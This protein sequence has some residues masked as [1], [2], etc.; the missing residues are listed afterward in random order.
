[1]TTPPARRRRPRWASPASGRPPPAAGCDAP[2]TAAPE[3]PAR[4]RLPSRR[5]RRHRAD[6]L[7]QHQVTGGTVPPIV[8]TID[9]ACPPEEV[10][11]YVTDPAR[12]GEWQNDVLRV[13]VDGDRFRTVRRIGGVERVMTQQI[14]AVDPPRRWAA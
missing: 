3:D 1:A 8:S 4:P 6:E 12:F 13:H 9:I 14:T 2:R 7:H 10:F 11:A 5:M